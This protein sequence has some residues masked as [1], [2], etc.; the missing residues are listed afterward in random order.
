MPILIPFLSWLFIYTLG[1]YIPEVW[2]I[3]LIFTSNI[4][5]SFSSAINKFFGIPFF[6]YHCL[7]FCPTYQHW[8]CF[9]MYVQF[10]VPF[11][12][13][14][15]LITLINLREKILVWTRIRTRVSSS[16]CWKPGF[17][18]WFRWEFSLFKLATKEKGFPV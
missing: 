11:F 10:W 18:S 13:I 9:F 1:I 3:T 16:T 5:V 8:S 2:F 14:Q 6:S 7:W 12:I 4:L 15:L 17:E